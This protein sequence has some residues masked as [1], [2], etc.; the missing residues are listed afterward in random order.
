MP[1]VF[2]DV[3]SLPSDEKKNIEEF[4]IELSLPSNDLVKSNSIG[5]PLT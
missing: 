1:D 2:S 3:L 4:V 5:A